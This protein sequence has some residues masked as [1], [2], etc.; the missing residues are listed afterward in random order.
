MLYGFTLNG[1]S[2]GGVKFGAVL[3]PVL[4]GATTI[5]RVRLKTGA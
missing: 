4:S 2:T 1:N 3:D 5:V